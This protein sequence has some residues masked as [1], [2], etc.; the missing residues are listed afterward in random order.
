VAWVAAVVVVIVFIVIATALT[1]STGE[2]PAVF[3]RGD[4][5][6]MIGLGLAAALAI[7]S[8]TRPRVDADEQG[9]KI[10]NV[11]GGYQLPW[12]VVRAVTFE[13]GHAWASLELVDNDVV[14]MM[15]VQAA[16]R[17]YAVEALRKLRELHAASLAS[18]AGA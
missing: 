13:R 17:Q 5:L 10:R 14:A 12:Q 16:D 1:G 15:A 9:I 3:R 4:Q 7:L 18:G 2:G 8:L 6:A 11:I